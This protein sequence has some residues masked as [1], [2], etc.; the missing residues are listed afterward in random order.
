VK[1]TGLGLFIVRSIARNH[2]GKVFAQ[3]E[4]AGKGTTVTL[5]LPR[6]LEKE[7]SRRSTESRTE[8]PDQAQQESS[9]ESRRT[10]A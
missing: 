7:L 4:G 3:S 10:T 8:L 5:E 9:R 6:L 2:G 1:G